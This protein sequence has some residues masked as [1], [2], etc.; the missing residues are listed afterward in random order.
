MD[1]LEPL[2]RQLE[3]APR[4]SGRGKIIAVLGAQ[5]DAPRAAVARAFARRVALQAQ[6]AIW[7]IDLDVPDC[8][9]AQALTSVGPLS[10]PF[11]LTLGVRAFWRVDGAPAEP[12]EGAPPDPGDPGRRV[13]TLRQVGAS[14]LH[15]SQFHP[16]A[17]PAGAR[18]SLRDAPDYWRTA[19]RAADVVVVDAPST[20]RSGAWS[21]IAPFADACILV[22]DATPDG[23]EATRA[24]S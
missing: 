8:P 14:A 23:L 13:M 1:A 20:R 21:H 15:V 5:D 24:S 12:G 3:A 9:H 17:L 19:R 7:L 18:A 22:T 10:A 4:A 2:A 11:D 6:R 16:R